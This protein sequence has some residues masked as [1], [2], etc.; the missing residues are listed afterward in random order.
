MVGTHLPSLPFYLDR[1]VT[2]VT[3]RR[4]LA[5]GID[6]EPEKA[7]AKPDVFAETWK[8]QKQ[9]AAMFLDKDYPSYIERF[10]LPGKIIYQGSKYTAIV[11]SPSE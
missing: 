6:A 8:R 7:I 11:R 3:H 10:D 2:V 9:G 4:E 5:M 1:V